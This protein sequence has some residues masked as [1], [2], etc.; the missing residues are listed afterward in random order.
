M[1]RARAYP[2]VVAAMLCRGATAA[3][4]AWLQ[5]RLIMS[6]PPADE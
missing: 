2:I 3:G 1:D 4:A 6:G 5:R